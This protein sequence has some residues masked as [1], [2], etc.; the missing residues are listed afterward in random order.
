MKQLFKNI[1]KTSLFITLLIH[2]LVFKAQAGDAVA[3]VNDAKGVVFANVNGRTIQLRT[4]D[5]ILKDSEILTTSTGTITF[6]DYFDHQYHLANSSL[7]KLFPT[8]VQLRRGFVWVQSYREGEDEFTLSTA[9]SVVKFTKGEGIL[10]FDPE[11][12]KSQL[13]VVSGRFFIQNVQNRLDQV[14][15]DDGNFSY[16]QTSL[17]GG[18][19]RKATPVGYSSFKKMT[20]LFNKV[21]PM[22]TTD[23]IIRR[24]KSIARKVPKKSLGRTPAAFS[25]AKPA[26]P[27][28]KGEPLKFTAAPGKGKVTFFKGNKVVDDDYFLSKQLKKLSKK[29]RKPKPLKKKSQKKSQ[30]KIRI[31]GYQG[32]AAS[33]PSMAGQKSKKV[34]PVNKALKSS[35]ATQTGRKPASLPKSMPIPKTDAFEQGLRREYKKQSRHSTEV[36]KPYS[37]PQK[38]RSR[39]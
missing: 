2:F 16:I 8:D 32:T 34:T 30:V 3:I 26:S 35:A 33:Y 36:N 25:G 14:L 24:N 17:N 13:L 31:F 6:T 15:V 10:S 5:E 28:M 21:K 37:G 18:S 4:G 7:V 27:Q 39:L 19:P 29:A 20:S 1:N 9:N 11:S 22:S 38:L 23:H 12:T